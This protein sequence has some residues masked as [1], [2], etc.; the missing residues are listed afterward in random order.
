MLIEK[1][2]DWYLVSIDSRVYC[3]RFIIY[4]LFWYIVQPCY[5]LELLCDELNTSECKQNKFDKKEGEKGSAEEQKSL[6][7]K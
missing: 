4:D 3:L 6:R 7:T 2:I 1:K 5:H